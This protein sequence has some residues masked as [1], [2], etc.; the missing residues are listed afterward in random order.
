MLIKKMLRD[1]KHNKTQFIS[2][3]LM[4][5]LGVFIYAGVGGEWYGLQQT[6]NKYYQDTNLANVWIYGN[7]FSE[8]DVEAVSKVDGVSQVQRR[9]SLEAVAVLDNSPSVTLHFIEKNNISKAYRVT[10]EDFSAQKDGIWLDDQFAGARHLKTGDTVTVTAFGVKLEKKILGTVL[11]PEYVYSTG[12]NDIV[13]NHANY[14]FA[15]M[16]VSTFPKQMKMVYTELLITTGKTPDASLEDRINSALNG[17]YSVYLD[18]DNFGS[19]SMFYNEIQQHKAMGSVF[20][21][22]FLAIALLTI[23]TTMTRM[24][25]NQRTQIGTLKALGF[26]KR[27]ILLHYISY[28][29]WLSLAGAVTG[30]IVGP[31]TLPRL[32]YSTMQITYTLPEWKPSMSPLFFTMALV[33]V[34]LCTLATYWACRS[35]LRDTPSQTLRP[36]APKAMKQ[37]AYENT[38]FWAGLG[39]NAQW[40]LRDIL[41]S[42]LRSI[43]AVVGVLGC[44]ALLVCAFGLQDTLSDVVQWQYSDLYRFSTKLSLSEGVSEGTAASVLKETDGQALMEGAVEVKA[45]GIKKSGEIMVTDRVSLIKYT[46]AGRKFMELPSDRISISYKMSELLGVKAGDRVSWHIYGQEKWV[47]GE[48]GAVYRSPVSQG[49]TLTRELFEKS[50]FAFIPTAVITGLN[51]GTLP[52]GVESKWSKSD[53]TESYE[54]MAKAM[55]IMV[56]IL[57]TGAVLLAVVVLYNLGV[58]SFTER[59]RELATLKVI[60]FQS[61]KIR[62]LLL[63]QNI[64]LTVTGI[65]PGIFLGKW[66]ILLMLSFMGDSFDMMCIITGFNIIT[67]TIITFVLSVLVSFMFS[68]KIKRIDMVSSLKG[69]E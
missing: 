53:L 64:W 41:R 65:V 68:G 69:V 61:K 20:P 32:F 26:Q 54:T 8:E 25:N 13:P 37:G 40:N 9:L 44:T 6:S 28:G 10:G 49:I 38:A 51:V 34:L 47:T 15:Y 59:L 24:V 36:K 35:N 56:Y 52:E 29:F 12:G 42:K 5:F 45:N 48:I 3:F 17:H 18:R 7:N 33:T 50:G 46:D 21:V 57:I 19:Y 67:S 58:L 16:P 62:H 23:L 11:S 14:G 66:L 31:L 30:A 27:T 1:M 2:I 39:F 43:M 22:V 63:T 60:G 4:A 55:N